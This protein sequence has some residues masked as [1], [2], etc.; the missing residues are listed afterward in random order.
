MRA[1]IDVVAELVIVKALDSR[2]IT[3][4]RALLALLGGFILNYSSRR[5][6]FLD[7]LLWGIRR[8][9]LSYSCHRL[10]ILL[11]LIV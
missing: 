11:D 2:G 9:W 3:Y 6:L 10:L 1:V 8:R 7:Y 5:R 4:Y